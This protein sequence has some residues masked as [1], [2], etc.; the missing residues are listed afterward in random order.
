MSRPA[1]APAGLTKLCPECGSG[2]V[3]WCS[4]SVRPYCNECRHWGP[5]NFGSEQDAVDA[6]NKR[7]AISEDSDGLETWRARLDEMVSRELTGD[8]A[9]HDIGHFRRVAAV[10]LTIARK[11]G[12]DADPLV[13]L[14]SAYLHDA[15]NLHKNSPFRQLSS[16][17][18]A[19]EADKILTRMGMD[20]QRI[21]KVRHAIKAHSYS[22]GTAP[23]SIEAQI[24]QDA[25][26]LDA[27]GAIGIA[28]LFYT[29]GLL[30]QPLF[31]PEDPFCRRREPDD[32][33]WS[34]DHAFTKLFK[35]PGLMHTATGRAIADQRVGLIRRFLDDLGTEIVYDHDV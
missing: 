9:A 18:S 24:I 17:L 19:E 12:A 25:D 16:L 29:S 34:L 8:D 31:H 28:R 2:D 22:A 7:L 35:L 30:K 3:R 13:L 1:S 26:R 23:T 15:V 11:D 32:L 4:V 6:W 27:L 14:A 10:S 5:I 33:T 21:V 20:R